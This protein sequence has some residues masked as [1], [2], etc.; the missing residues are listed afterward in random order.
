MTSLRPDDR[1]IKDSIP[2]AGGYY[3][4]RHGEQN[5]HEA[6]LI[7]RTFDHSRPFIAEFWERSELNLQK[8]TKS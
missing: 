5:G 8:K 4:V 2:G 3:S 1:R 7:L 6:L